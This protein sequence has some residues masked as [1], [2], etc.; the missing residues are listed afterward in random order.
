[1]NEL[2]V[3]V[4]GVDSTSFPSDLVNKTC[5]GFVYQFCLMSK[6]SLDCVFVRVCVCLCV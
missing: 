5:I 1:M 2:G 6:E 4:V 3:G